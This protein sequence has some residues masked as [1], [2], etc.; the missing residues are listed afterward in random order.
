MEDELWRPMGAVADGTWSLDSDTNGFEKM[1]SGLNSRAID[2]I[3]LGLVYLHGG[4]LNGNRIITEHWVRE[5][6]AVTNANDP[7]A[8]YQ[9]QWW[10]YNDPE[11]GNWFGAQGNKGQFIAV[12]PRRDLVLARFGIDFGH[13][14]W[15]A[16]LATMARTLP[17]R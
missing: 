9:Y 11:L 10:T 7:S 13:D 12:F 3:K 14:D 4:A 15:P 6:T 16:L 5:A 2:M 1:E 17:R 8:E